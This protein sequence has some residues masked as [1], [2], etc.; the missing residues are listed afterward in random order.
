[1]WKKKNPVRIPK[2][3]K[4]FIHTL[5]GHFVAENTAFIYI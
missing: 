4:R 3:A 1:M 2:K 5:T